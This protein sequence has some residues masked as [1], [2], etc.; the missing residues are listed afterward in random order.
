MK[1]EMTLDQ[2]DVLGAIVVVSAIVLRAVNVFDNIAF[3][4]AM[5]IGSGFILASN[6]NLLSG[7]TNG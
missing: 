2:H 7:K 6:T 5:G 3:A 1:I 4:T